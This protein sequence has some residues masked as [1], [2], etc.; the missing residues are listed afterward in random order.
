[1]ML[2]PLRHRWRWLGLWL[3]AVATVI[4]LSLISLPSLPSLPSGSDKLEH[5]SAYF[6]LAAGAVQL[7]SGRR[8]LCACGVG[9]VVM[10]VAL[11]LAQG[12]YTDTRMQDGW[13]ALA[14]SLGVI[15]GL[16]TWLTPWR[17]ALLARQR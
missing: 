3:V 15:A 5:F 11:E 17:D 4:V 8:L 6:L 13:D 9:L 7:F 2:K 14:N 12:A 16:A 1:M 10:G